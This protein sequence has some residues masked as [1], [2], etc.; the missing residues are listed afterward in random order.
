MKLN[1]YGEEISWV[2]F[3]LRSMPKEKQTVCV[4]LSPSCV[5]QG[6]V[7][8]CEAHVLTDGLAGAESRMIDIVGL[9]QKSVRERGFPTSILEQGLEVK[10]EDTWCEDRTCKNVYAVQ[11]AYHTLY[12]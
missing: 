10:I 1:L 7:V 2:S 9:R 6:Y 5:S 3:R 12:V 11:R 4:F 8:L